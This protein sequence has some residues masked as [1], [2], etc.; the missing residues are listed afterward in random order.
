MTRCATPALETILANWKQDPSPYDDPAY[1]V[2]TC[3]REKILPETPKTQPTCATP[4]MDMI[5]KLEREYDQRIAAGETKEAVLQSW[6]DRK[7][8]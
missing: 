3:Q 8:C 7:G 4:A 5:F 6:K 2:P 1:D